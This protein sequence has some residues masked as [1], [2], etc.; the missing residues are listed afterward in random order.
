[1]LI[2]GGGTLPCAQIHAAY[3]TGLQTR[4]HF[5]FQVSPCT[6][7]REV[8]DMFVKQTN[9]SVVLKG[10]DSPVYADDELSNFCLV[11]VIGARERCLR[12]DFRLV[13]LQKPWKE[14]RLYVRR[15]SNVLAAIEC[16]AKQ[17]P[18]V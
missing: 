1:M 10:K 11:A 3:N 5:K 8:V 4:V 13:Q 17:S 15:K 7:A 14:G 18:Y 2:W 9:M 6:T 12:D 16:D